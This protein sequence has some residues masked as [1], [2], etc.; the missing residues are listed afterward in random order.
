M[1]SRT[2][3][4]LIMIIT[5]I[6]TD[7]FLHKMILNEKKISVSKFWMFSLFCCAEFLIISLI[8]ISNSAMIVAQ[9]HA[10]SQLS[11]TLLEEFICSCTPIIII[12]QA[13]IMLYGFYKYIFLV[14]FDI[15]FFKE[16]FCEDSVENV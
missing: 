3:I 5:F 6:F 16:L 4:F 7:Y 1:I 11:Y 13:V 8:S 10:L 14:L 12:A 15:P 9:T 2:I